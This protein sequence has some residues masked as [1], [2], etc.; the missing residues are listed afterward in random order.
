MNQSLES[1]LGARYLGHNT[2]AFRVW[3]PFAETV[4][5]HLYLDRAERFVGLVNQDNGYFAGAIR[6]I[7]PGDRYRYRV[8]GDRELADPASRW[9]PDGVLGPSAVI[10]PGQFVWHDA[11]WS[12]HRWESLVFYEVHVGTFSDRGQFVDV[13]PDLPRLSAMGITAIEIMPI[14]AFPGERNWGYDG[15]F[16]Y[17][18]QSSYG[19]PEGFARLVDA[20]HQHQLS[21]FLDVVYNHT[22]PEGSVLSQFGPYFNTH[23]HTPWGQAFNFDGPESDAVRAF[24]LENARQWIV[25]YHVDGLRLDAVHAIIDTSAEPFLR[26]MTRAC[27]TM[28]E[29]SG[30][31]VHLVAESDRNDPREIM[32]REREG[33]GFSGQWNDDL[34]HALHALITGER[35]GYY[36]DYGTLQDLCHALSS[37]YVYTGQYSAYRKR[38]H[39]RRYRPLPLN[40]IVTYSQNHD[41]IGNRPVGD[42]LTAQLSDAQRRLVAATIVLAPATPLLFM[43]EEY[44]EDHPFPYFVDHQDPALLQAV[45]EGRA[46]EWA[47]RNE[48][49][50]DPADPN[51]FLSAKLSS[52]RNN[53]LST[54]YRNLLTVRREY[55]NPVLSS[56]GDTPVTSTCEDPYPMISLRYQLDGAE[57]RI[58]LNFSPEPTPYR[59]DDHLAV[60]MNSATPESL[61][62]AH[63]SLP[64]PP[65]VPGH[66]CLVTYRH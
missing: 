39:G 31:P 36:Q 30:R 58:W 63:R 41:Q 9:Q 22:G 7:G 23:Y 55:L 49:I 3:A 17:A 65:V 64:T 45:R 60:L 20:C 6:G 8:D 34:H 11:G 59:H 61:G 5:V 32:G 52:H 42:R 56:N 57:L 18:P 43:G 38:R 29:T 54:W 40:R 48:E 24:F 47:Y 13:I 1:T 27:D 46:R 44:A 2:T 26:E 37:G 14:A 66:S 16:P 25:D 12:G 10:D 19:R 4:D 28:A 51:T 15:V 33:L 53:R 21:V 35:H 50:L 62:T